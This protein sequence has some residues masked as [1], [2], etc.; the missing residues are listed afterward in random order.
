MS[1]D[2]TDIIQLIVGAEASGSRLDK[3]VAAA[4]SELSR[5]RVQGLIKA[6]NVMVDGDPCLDAKCK[7]R[8]N[9]KVSVALPPLEP[10]GIMAEAIPLNIVYEDDDVIVVDKPAGLVT[11]PAPGHTGGTLVNALLAHA[12]KS[13]SGIGGVARPGIVHRLDKDTSGL[14]VIAKNDYAHKH[15]AQQFAAHG[16]DGR[17][18]RIYSAFTWGGFDRPRGTVD[19]PLGRSTTNRRKIKIVSGAYGRH[20]VSHYWVQKQY[21]FASGV[22]VSQLRLQLETGRTH[23]IRV[24]MASIGHPLLG[25]MT[26]G[27]G[28]KSSAVNLPERSADALDALGR[29]ALHAVILAFQHPRSGD[30]M[31][32]ESPLPSDLASLAA[33]LERDYTDTTDI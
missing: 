20:A 8:E 26:Y 5:Q 29:Q 7:V 31:H 24:H 23:Q 33:A 13:L 3:F 16:S 22:T 25:D 11:H 32:F 12:G 30:V 19:A 15:L 27:M 9:Q 17:M 21:A 18:Q 2:R 1:G 10:A 6:G 14:I 4:V 28:F